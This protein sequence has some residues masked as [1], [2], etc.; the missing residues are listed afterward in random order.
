MKDFEQVRPLDDKTML[1]MIN[2]I[3]TNYT[4]EEIFNWNI[5]NT[6]LKSEY[7]ETKDYIR[8]RAVWVWPILKV[9]LQVTD[10]E[11]AMNEFYIPTFSDYYLKFHP[12]NSI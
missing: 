4:Y 2:L 10:T 6:Y 8:A 11:I 1:D 12:L 3:K 9:Y 7:L 5:N